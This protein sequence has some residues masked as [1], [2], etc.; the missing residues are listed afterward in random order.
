MV[1]LNN[2]RSCLF[3][4]DRLLH[5]VSAPGTVTAFGVMDHRV[6]GRTFAMNWTNSQSVVAAAETFAARQD[7]VCL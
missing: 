2:Y 5:P 1:A 3:T 6:D 4:H 7:D